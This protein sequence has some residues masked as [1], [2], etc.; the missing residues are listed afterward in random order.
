MVVAVAASGWAWGQLNP[1]GLTATS[2]WPQGPIDSIALFLSQ[3]CSFP[4]AWQAH[5]IGMN[6]ARLE[7]TATS[8]ILYILQRTR[9]YPNPHI[10]PS[11]RP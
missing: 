6:P 8:Y 11:S 9:I 4:L 7:G 3:S 1:V 5:A 2:R 10:V